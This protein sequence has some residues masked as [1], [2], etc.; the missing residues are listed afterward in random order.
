MEQTTLILM[1]EQTDQ[2]AIAMIMVTT[3]IIIMEM[4]FQLEVA[5]H[6]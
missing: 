2:V 6:L 1:E 4:D 5:Q 3:K